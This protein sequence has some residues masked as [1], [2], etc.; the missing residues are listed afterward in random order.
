VSG[1]TRRAF[2]QAGGAAAGTLVLGCSSTPRATWARTARSDSAV[3]DAWLAI[4]PDDRILVHAHKVEMGQGTYTAFATLVGEELRTSPQ[5]IELV[6]APVDEAF[7]APMQGTGGSSSL[8]EIWQPL[9][10][11]GARAREMLKAAAA[12]HWGVEPEAL[13][14]DEG[15]VLHP[16]GER[17][18]FGRL[19]E[20]A[21]RRPAPGAVA[22]TPP[23]QWR[24]VGRELPRV[25][26]PAKVSGRAQYGMDVRV[27]ELRT[28]VV[29]HCPH[30]LGSLQSFDDGPVRA[31]PG[32]EDVFELAD[33]IAIVAQ[34]YWSARSAAAKL[35]VS[36]DPGESKGVD[37]AAIRNGL[38]NAL[39][40]G[41]LHSA[42]D[43]GDASKALAAAD[44]VFEA[45]YAL[46]YLAHATM[47]PMN[48]TVAPREG[49]CDVYL[50][51]QSPGLV[52]DAVAAEL[53][54]ARSDV[55]VH[56]QFLGG[57][58]GRRFF[59]DMAAEAA[60]IAKRSGKPI[61]L[62][63]SREDDM[64]RDYYRPPS[65]HRLR[66]T[67]AEDGAPSAWQH[68]LAAPSLIPHMADAAGAMGPQWMRGA[69]MSLATGLARRLPGWTGP[70]LAVEGANDQPYAIPNVAVEAVAW[71][72]GIPVGIWRSVG[73][74]HNGFVVE[75]FI[76][77]LAHAAGSDPAAYRRRLLSEHPRHQRVLDRLVDEAR[78]GQPAEGR[79]QGIAIHESFGSVVG[80][81][82]EVSVDGGAL[83]VHRVTCVVD[84]GFA[85][86]PDMV[87]AQME[88]SVHFGLTA[89]LYGEIHFDDGA[90]VESNF[91]DHRMLR[92]AAAPEVV[93]HI[94]ASDAP[95]S[96]VGEPG[97]PPIAP[98][99]AN[100]V[101]AATGQRLR[102]L[103]LRLA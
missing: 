47:E 78:W 90:A 39:D 63:W 21:A 92:M 12:E 100:A 32:V 22:L 25:D 85:V 56:N 23:E 1:L 33:G 14:V 28:A 54:I 83:R 79:H 66:A 51:T 27:P 89:A 82:A 95:P 20:A 62:V 87:G 46:P 29:V 96:G 36:W 5:R 49:G 73:H 102:E 24:Y 69:M 86:N 31:H 55:V 42:R 76:D 26:A 65:L 16:G 71:D 77:E 30:P 93:V 101:F 6:S 94:A 53:D 10:E 61:K 75:S 9:R 48:C 57:G 88:S 60:A 97:T 67:L 81:V 3:F 80:Q 18:S 64:A 84:C 40:S 35:E 52:Q 72:P 58:F 41:D 13:S 43:D 44:R 2:L 98:A 38:A 34:G 103:P 4:T 7:G 74:S 70:I 50:G 19:A 8:K 11:T 15:A 68:K 99:V 37:S 45:E 59:S 17:I 91:H